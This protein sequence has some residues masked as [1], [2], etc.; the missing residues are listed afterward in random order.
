MIRSFHTTEKI[1]AHPHNLPSFPAR[2]EG[3]FFKNT[4]R[5]YF[6]PI[7]NMGQPG[8]RPLR[9]EDD[10]VSHDTGILDHNH[11]PYITVSSGRKQ[12]LKI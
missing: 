4:L 6:R 10:V 1:M 11:C 12:C 3:S 8:D 2:E 9:K 7:P 5:H